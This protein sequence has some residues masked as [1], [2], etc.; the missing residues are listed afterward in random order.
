MALGSDT[1]PWGRVGMES[2]L[3]LGGRQCSKTALGGGKNTGLGDKLC[4]LGQVH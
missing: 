3:G 4:D 2:V 1:I